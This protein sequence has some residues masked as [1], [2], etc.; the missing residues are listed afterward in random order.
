MVASELN[1]LFSDWIRFCNFII[2]AVVIND[3]NHGMVIV[4]GKGNASI[5]DGCIGYSFP[6][7]TESMTELETHDEAL[8][9]DERNWKWLGATDVM[10]GTNLHPADD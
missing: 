1:P 4:E 2:Y 6:T 5:N 3:L 8:W 10:V 7:I 9:N